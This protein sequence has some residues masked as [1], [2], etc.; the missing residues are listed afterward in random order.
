M[1]LFFAMFMGVFLGF[2]EQFG[3][4]SGMPMM[5]EEMPSIGFL[6]IFYPFM[7]SFGAAFFNT[8]LYVIIAFVYN[9]IAKFIGG[10]ELEFNEVHLQPVNYAPT[11]PSYQPPPPPQRPPSPPPPPPPVEPMPP[12]ITPPTDE[13][14]NKEQL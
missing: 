3:G 10:L 13:D 8:I 9:S 4:M 11:P 12:E 14:D 6:L 5:T 2:I 1:G 7:F